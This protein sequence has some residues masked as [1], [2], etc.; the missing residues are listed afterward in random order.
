[1]PSAAS[2]PAGSFANPIAGMVLG[3][4]FVLRDRGRFYLYGT[5]E[6][7]LRVDSRLPPDLQTQLDAGTLP[8]NDVTDE[9]PSW[10]WA[11]GNGISTAEDMVT[12]IDALVGGLRV[13]SLFRPVRASGTTLQ[14]AALI[15]L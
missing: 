12:W 14:I 3:D 15:A 9:N 4:P 6:I 13:V 7:F 11:A 1:M 5:N 2:R 8:L 10:G